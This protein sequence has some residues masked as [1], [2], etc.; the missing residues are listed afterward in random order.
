MRFSK[1]LRTHDEIEEE[2]D[3][4]NNMEKDPCEQRADDHA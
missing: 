2:Q 3:D 4:D 1:A